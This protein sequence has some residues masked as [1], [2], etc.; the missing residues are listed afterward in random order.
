[1]KKKCE[2]CIGLPMADRM[3]RRRGQ[4]KSMADGLKADPSKLYVRDF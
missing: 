1:M 3:K 4:S 2:G